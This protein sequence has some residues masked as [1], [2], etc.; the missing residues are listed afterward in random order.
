MTAGRQFLLGPETGRL[1]FVQV[2]PLG[3]VP[4]HYMG[5]GPSVE[6]GTMR[7]GGFRVVPGNGLLDWARFRGVN[8]QC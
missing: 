6:A 5:S 1:I 4:V 2:P 3:F 7:R 8:V